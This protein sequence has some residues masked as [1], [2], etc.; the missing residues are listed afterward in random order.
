MND[1]IISIVTPVHAPAAQYLADAYASIRAQ[2]LPEGW[3]WQWVI[4]EDGTSTEVLAAIPDDP[5]ISFGTGRAGGPAVART[6]SLSR[7]KGAVVQVLDADDQFTPGTLHRVIE[8]L[9]RHRD[10]GWTTTRVI[11]LRVDGTTQGFDFDPP[12]GRLPQGSILAHW[13]TH[14]YRA[15]VHPA[16]LAIRRELLLELGGWMALPASE[17]TGL[18]L[19]LDATTDGYFIPDTGLIYRKW[20]GQMTAQTEHVSAVERAARFRVIEQ[21]A[22]AIARRR[23][24]VLTSLA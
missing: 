1:P 5:R 9:D 12:P 4:Q 7:V 14:D 2:I 23:Q 18:L 13:Q 17:D 20:P 15:S 3:D 22:L 10:I 6:L 21:R 11:D 24:T 16:T 19:A 8:V